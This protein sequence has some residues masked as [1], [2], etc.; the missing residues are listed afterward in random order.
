M[1]IPQSFRHSPLTKFP[2]IIPLSYKPISYT[3]E[4]AQQLA[5]VTT[6]DALLPAL[7]F[8]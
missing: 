5:S 6:S 2:T 8:P 4:T 7:L 3:A 1:L